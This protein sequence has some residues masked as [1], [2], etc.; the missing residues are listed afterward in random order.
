[1]SVNPININFT[2]SDIPKVK[3]KSGHVIDAGKKKTRIKF[4]AFPDKL[5]ASLSEKIL[6][7]PPKKNILDRLLEFFGRRKWVSLNVKDLN[8]EE[9]G[10]IKVNLNSL[11]KRFYISPKEL[12][13]ALQNNKTNDVTKLISGDEA[14][15]RAVKLQQSGKP[16]EA[17]QEYQRAADLGI[18]GGLVGLALLN[19][20]SESSLGLLQQAAEK[21][22][23][24]ATVSYTHLTLPTI[25]SV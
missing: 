19:P 23:T 1:M 18:A 6:K 7:E 22:N 14:L 24:L 17:R 9:V 21:D 8:T 15:L 5:V 10:Y 25:Y 3:L 13:E 2:K 16:E 4:E 11:Q 12:D 20:L